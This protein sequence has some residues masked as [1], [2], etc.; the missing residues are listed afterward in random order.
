[1]NLNDERIES[2]LNGLMMEA[3]K[4][5]FETEVRANKKLWNHIQFQQ[6]LIAGI[7]AD[8][9][10]EL[11]NFI[12]NRITEE[13]ENETTKRYWGWIIAATLV[14]LLAGFAVLFRLNQTNKSQFEI[15]SSDSNWGNTKNS[16]SNSKS[17][18]KSRAITGRAANDLEISADSAIAMNEML[19]TTT[20]VPIAIGSEAN[21]RSL[22]RVPAMDGY[23][24]VLKDSLSG[25]EINA[26]LANLDTDTLIVNKQKLASYNLSIKQFNIQVVNVPNLK[27]PKSITNEFNPKSGEL[28]ITL[29]NLGSTDMV[30]YRLESMHYLEVAGE[31][32]LL[33]TNPSCETILSPISDNSL[34]KKL[35]NR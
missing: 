33:C 3:E 14:A 20:I 34:L 2:Y 7:K 1:M 13:K 23:R 35:K 5:A 29:F 24:I 30:I 28:Y 9:S 22:G 27:K 21:L 16:L 26:K 15:S 31:F 17:S 11:K 10:E 19:I 25:S 4:M 8:G 6:F 32:Y 18:A 12:A